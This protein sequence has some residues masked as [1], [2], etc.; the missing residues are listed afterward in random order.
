[1]GTTPEFIGVTNYNFALGGRWYIGVYNRTNVNVQYTLCVRQ[2]LG[3]HYPNVD[4]CTNGI[5]IQ[6][7]TVQYFQHTVSP[8]ALRTHFTVSNIV[9]GGVDMYITG[10]PPQP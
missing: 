1:L 4:L 3:L 5:T 6:P 7:G 8:V 9:N 10:Y 2:V